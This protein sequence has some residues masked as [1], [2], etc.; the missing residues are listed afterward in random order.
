M[1]SF[2]LALLFSFSAFAGF[3]PV[4]ST[5]SAITVLPGQ[6]VQCNTASA[7]QFGC[8]QAS[9]F[10]A[11]NAKA[12]TDSPAFT[13]TPTAPTPS[14]GDSSTKLATTAWVNAQG[15]LSAAGSMPSTTVTSTT[16][17]TSASTSF[18]TALTTTITTT[19]ASAP[20]F[21]QCVMDLTSATAASV[22]NT[23]VTINGVA[24]QTVSESITTATTQH[25][26]VAPQF[27]SASLSPGTYTV[28]CDI[29]R[30]SGTGTVTFNQG[31]LS[32]VGLQ[33]ASSNG[34]TQLT[35]ALTAGPGS[36]SQVLSGVL[37]VANGGTH[38]S[39]TTANQLLYSSATNV[40][41]GLATANTGALV[42]SS[43]GVPS[44]TSGATANRVLRTNGTTVSFAQVAAATDIS[45]TLAVTNGGTGLSSVAAQRIPFGTGSTTLATDGAF[46]WD[47]A[48]QR[49][50]AGGFGTATGNFL[51]TSGNK[52]ALQAFNSSAGN[53][54]QSTNVSAY[55]AA[56][57]NRS[58]GAA[59]GASIGLEFG[60]GTPASPTQ[61]L[62]GDQ[63]GVIAAT[64]DA[65][66]GVAHGYAGAI[67]FVASEDALT[68]S[69]GGEL[70]LSTTPNGGNL[71]PVER[72][73]VTNDGQLKAHY[74][75][76]VDTAG[77]QPACDSAHRGLW[78]VIQGGVGVADTLQICLKDAAN[79]YAWL[80]K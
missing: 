42:T 7:A 66:D 16:P 45:G 44:I 54:F 30:S 67:S 74:G 51:V 57:I 29:A 53:A 32:A 17:V 6:K 56:L 76:S 14:N 20:V 28:N 13:G 68:T 50:M 62:N 47:T 49:F 58:N 40:I 19:A 61:A 80:T 34:I 21:A 15:Y 37:P 43:S 1:G 26:Q 39:S 25:L 72:V 10:S 8:L 69:T 11:F 12:P 77:S 31:A 73:R 24:G 75:V 48:N 35:G 3:P 52:T 60:R 64:P 79:N 65:S 38:L 9:D 59:N 78:W 4:T 70:A 18:V 63:I 22:A 23:R 33:G 2:F 5:N 41:A 36:G 55:T 46:A 71:V 27:T